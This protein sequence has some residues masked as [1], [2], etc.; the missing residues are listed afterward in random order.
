MG[1]KGWGRVRMGN[2][3][4]RKGRGQDGDGEGDGS[5]RHVTCS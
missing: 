1:W 5:W 2:G 4:K 3:W